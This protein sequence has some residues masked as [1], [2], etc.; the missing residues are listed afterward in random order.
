[1]GLFD[2]PRFRQ[3]RFAIGFWVDP[4]FDAKAEARYRELA[5]AGFNLVLA[6]FQKLDRTRF[7]RLLRR[8]DLRAI[9]WQD[10]DDFRTGMDDPRIWG[11][12]LRDEPSAR[13]FP[14]L[15]RRAKALKAARPGQFAYVNLFPNYASPG[16]LGSPDYDTHVADFVRTVQPEVLS[17][18][19]YPL[20]R[21]DREGDG[22][23]RYCENLETLRVHALRAGIPFWNF[24][25]TM[26]Y[27]PHT[28][29]TESQL[30]WQVFASMAY[31]AKGVLWFCYYTPGGDE[32]F[33]KGGAIIARDDVPTHHYEQAR[34]INTVVANLG[35]TLMACTSTGVRRVRPG[36]APAA[37]LRGAPIVDLR[38][39]PVDPPGDYLVGT[40]R[41]ADGRRAVLL[42][43][44]R[45]THTAW[46]TV[47][48][49]APDHLVR[50]VDPATGREI[51]VR[52]ESPKMPGIQV[53]LL[54]GG[55][56]L[57]VLP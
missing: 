13:D 4:P 39:A 47:V 11:T 29:P 42:M 57:F 44:H 21:P 10:G 20:F 26:P 24:F 3:D 38:K 43:N 41:H 53:P 19:H 34:R 33:P 28:D 18:D 49:D 15:A 37:V 14:D 5:S 48:F 52:D 54:D 16:Q 23:E 7:L 25:N 12:A 40:F 51:P 45:T 30:R 22:R 8:H 55:G 46:P 6:G 1:M 17:M 9:V 32:E 36:E 31:G 35:R 56:R 50:E 27:G 2:P